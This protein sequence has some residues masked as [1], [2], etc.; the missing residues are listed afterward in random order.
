MTAPLPRT[1]RPPGQAI[2]RSLSEKTTALATKGVVCRGRR[3]VIASR[4]EQSHGR[5]AP[6]LLLLA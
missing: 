6:A 5:A 3:R 4:R 1:T 2:T